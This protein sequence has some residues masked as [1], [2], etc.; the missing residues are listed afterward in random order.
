VTKSD[1]IVVTGHS[2]G[3]ALAAICALDLVLSDITTGENLELI[4]FG[5]PRVGNAEYAAAMD[6][7]V[8]QSYRVVNKRDLVP[9]LPL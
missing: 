6:K 8:P 3:G 4:T 5:E 1:T 7:Y 2:L 9:H